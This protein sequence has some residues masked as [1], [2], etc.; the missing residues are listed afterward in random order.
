MAR[1][2]ET[3][4]H[5]YII[6]SNTS[7]KISKDRIEKKLEHRLTGTTTIEL[8]IMKIVFD[9]RSEPMIFPK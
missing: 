3:K 9:I 1:V 8:D 7:I 4:N 6:G 5:I 2:I